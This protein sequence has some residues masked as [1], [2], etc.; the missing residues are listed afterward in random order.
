MI[1]VAALYHFTRF[2]DP[3]ALR[4]PLIALCNQ[5]DVKGSL[6]LAGEGVNGTIAGSRAG[7]DAV[8]A[9]LRALSGCATLEHKESLAPKKPFRHMKVKLK[10]EIVTMGQPDIDPVARVGSYVAPADWNALIDQ[11]DVVLIDTRNDY[12]V[13]IGT[14]QGA[15]DPDIK[16]FRAFPKWWEEHREDFRGKRVAMFPAGAGRQRGVSPQRR[17]P[18]ISRR[19]A[20]RGVEVGWRMLCL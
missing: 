15:I 9:H 2:P 1:I 3:D 19:G 20:C 5:H 10:R 7:V 12:E 11:P 16:T 14:F 17:H 13:G 8:L 4:A 18:E 6:L